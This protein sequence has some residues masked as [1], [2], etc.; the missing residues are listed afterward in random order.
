MQ[1]LSQG[2]EQD[3][4]GDGKAND[5]QS[6][7]KFTSGL[8]GFFDNIKKNYF[9]NPKDE[10]KKND[11]DSV[12]EQVD[13][14]SASQHTNESP[15]A[16]QEINAAPNINGAKQYQL[17]LPRPGAG[18]SPPR[19][20]NANFRGAPYL[21]QNNGRAQKNYGDMN[22]LTM[23]QPTMENKDSQVMSMQVFNQKFDQLDQFESDNL[24]L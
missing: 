12:K 6:N 15:N 3:V 11:D 17:K 19:D 20:A 9:N 18:L 7:G 16:G 22:I 14:H 21:Q 23:S 24:R 2:Q 5:T 13:P 10:E 4:T 8:L 1:E